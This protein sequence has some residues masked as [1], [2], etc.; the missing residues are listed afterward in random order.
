MEKGEIWLVELPS[1][2]GHEQAGMRPAVVISEVSGIV[3]IIPVT[4]NLM[5]LRFDYSFSIK[6]SKSNGLASES[7]AMIFQLRAIDKKRLKKEIGIL[8]AH[9]IEKIDDMMRKMMKL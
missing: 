1:A 3:L 8:E 6:P 2:N 4:S 9:Y 5:A 7:V